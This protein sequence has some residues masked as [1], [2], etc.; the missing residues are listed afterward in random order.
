[1]NKKVA[2]IVDHP[3]RDLAGL[4]LIGT[5]LAS[6]GI[7]VYFCSHNIASIELWKIAPD[8][9]L[10]NYLR[11]NN[12]KLAEEMHR[13]GIKYGVLDT[14]GGVF[15]EMS[16]FTGALAKSE[17]A[18]SNCSGFYC[19]GNKVKD[20]L[21]DLKI[22]PDNV[23][24]VTGQPRMDFYHDSLSPII[25]RGHN[26]SNEYDDFI[27]VNGVFAFCNPRF[28]TPEKE[29]EQSIEL[30]GI[31]RGKSIANQKREREVM[32]KMIDFIK[33]LAKRYPNE[34]FVWRPHPFESDKIYSDSFKDLPNA[35]VIQKGTVDGW[36]L[37]A[38]ALI[39]VGCSTAFEAGFTGLPVFTPT[40]IGDI[41]ADPA[42]KGV[43]D[44]VE[45]EQLFY[46]KFDALLQNKYQYC[47][48]IK[49]NTQ[50]AIDEIYYKNDGLSYIRVVDK[51][52]S[53]I[54]PNDGE[55]NLEKCRHYRNKIT[56][57][58]GD[59]IWKKAVKIT[60]KAFGLAV[61]FKFGNIHHIENRIIQKWKKTPKYLSPTAFDKIFDELK[62]S[63]S[64]WEKVSRVE[65]E[66][67]DLKD[68]EVFSLKI[69]K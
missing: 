26:D 4:I 33:N 47:D 61:F 49:E 12:E 28:S 18:I 56:I 13:A 66:S 21:V 16:V 69:T 20:A 24:D 34:K 55:V 57:N 46:E 51:I 40:W 17:Y 25:L 50:K 31:E 30:F 43:S 7:D 36:L 62:M 54:S 6:R 39:Q 68:D 63:K 67:V 29:V 32:L 1:V 15:P 65:F 35:E 10:L 3:D 8:F 22:F 37:K 48:S 38:K 45:S 60:I 2:I 42:I 52:T 59:Q 41:Y 53:E 64:N 44:N 58:K 27:L 11:T 9:V 23:V 14:E 5:E 19:W